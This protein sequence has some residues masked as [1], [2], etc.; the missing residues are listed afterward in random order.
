MNSAIETIAPQFE[1]QAGNSPVDVPL[2]E[3]FAFGK[4]WLRFSRLLTEERINESQNQLSKWLGIDSLAGKTFLDIG[5]GSGL[6]SLAAHR[7]GATI[8][9]FDFDPDSVLCTQEVRK[10]WGQNSENWTVERG[11]AIDPTFMGSLGQYD[12]V[13]SWGVLHHTGSMYVG[14]DLA[15]QRV[16]PGGLLF[17]S[18]YNDQG[19]TSRHWRRLKRLYVASPSFLKTL[20]VL[21]YI[22]YYTMAKGWNILFGSFVR[23][24][25]L[26]NPFTPFLDW[27]NEW[28]N[29]RYERGMDW[30]HDVVD[31]VGGYPFEVAKPEEIFEF[32]KARGFSL[33]RLHTCGGSLGCNQFVFRKVTTDG[34]AASL[35]GSTAM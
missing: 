1:S 15:A 13:Y 14:L 20:I 9:A 27:A 2:D 10:R 22:T 23:L 19:I 17:V 5:C 18:I 26:R 29:P 24:V 16:A 34:D 12:V 33:E 4:N 32:F 28:W 21:G 8:R 30:W 3:R 35:D 6:S 25:T 7:L 11:S 31:W